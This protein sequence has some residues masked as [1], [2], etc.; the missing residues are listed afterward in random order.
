MLVMQTRNTSIIKD[1]ILLTQ[2]AIVR[3]KSAQHID[4]AGY[5][6][7]YLFIMYVGY[8]FSYLLSCSVHLII[9]NDILKVKKID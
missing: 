8:K 1:I 9:Y 6:T 7:L 3:A 4:G 5:K 2:L